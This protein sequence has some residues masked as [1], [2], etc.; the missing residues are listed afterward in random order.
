[1]SPN[2]GTPAM[3][4]GQLHLTRGARLVRLVTMERPAHAFKRGLRSGLGK[5]KPS[6]RATKEEPVMTKP[7]RYLGLDVHAET[8]SAAIAEG[9]SKV[10]SL[11]Q[12]PNRPE[13]VR[14]LLGKLGGFHPVSWTVG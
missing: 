12:I 3:A 5:K 13:A 1:M 6:R 11:G 4:R 14:K 7:T 10:R 2:L 9:D 8:I